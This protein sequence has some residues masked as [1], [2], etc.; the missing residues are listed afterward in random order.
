[1]KSRRKIIVHGTAVAVLGKD[2]APSA[3]LLRGASGRGKP[4]LSFRLIEAGGTLI[5]DDQVELEIRQEKIITAAAVEAIRGLMEVRGVGLLKFPVAPPTQ[6][7]LIVDLVLREEVPRLPEW[8][9]EDILGI[10]VVRLKLCAF[11]ASAPLKIAKAIEL[12]HKP[13]LLI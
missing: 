5:C 3:V 1:M 11:D 4:D 6:L 12:V 13:G 2:F 7:R 10:P 8:E 9:T